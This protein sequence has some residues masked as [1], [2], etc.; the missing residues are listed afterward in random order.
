MQEHYISGGLPKLDRLADD[1]RAACQNALHQHGARLRGSVGMQITVSG[2]HDFH[3]HV[4]DW[5]KEVYGS[6]GGY[7]AIRADGKK[8]VRRG[9]RDD[10]VGAL[11]NY[12]ESGHTVREA[13]GRA[14]QYRARIH[15]AR[16]HS[17]YFYK[18][19]ERDAERIAN[20]M[21]QQLETVVPKTAERSLL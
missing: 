6:N 17:F 20:E 1:I 21:R 5:Q 9:R 8:R 15:K 18:H 11:T 16:T 14:K 19:S 7:V 2:L 10:A 12:L 13:S 3:G 4:H